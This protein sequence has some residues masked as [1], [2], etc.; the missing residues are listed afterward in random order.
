MCERP[1]ILVFLGAPPSSGTAPVD[2]QRRPPP[3]WRHLELT[4]QEGRLRPAAGE[5][6]R[7]PYVGVGNKDEVFAPSLDEDGR[8]ARIGSGPLSQGDETKTDRRDVLSGAQRP[9][10]N[11]DPN[12]CPAL[13]HECPG[14]VHE[15]LDF[16]FPAAQPELERPSES[17]PAPAAPLLSTQTQFL[18]SWTLSQALILRGVQSARSPAPDTPPKVSSSTPELFSPVAPS[19]PAS[20][21]TPRVKEGGVVI[22]A[23]ADGVL[24]SQEEQRE[25]SVTRARISENPRT[26][27]S[28]AAP[29]CAG[30][31]PPATLLIHCDR[32]GVRYSVLVAAVHPCH[33]REV[34]VRTGPSAG[35]F[36]PLASIV[37]TDQSGVEM[38]VVLWR[39]AAFWVSTVRPGDV[40]LITGLQ[41]NEDRWRGE[42]VLQSTF[43]SKLLNLGQILARTSPPV[44]RNIDARSLSALCVSLRERRPSLASLNLHAPQDP[45]RLPYAILRSLRVDTLA[46]ALLRVTHTH[47]STEWRS[48]AESRCT[49]AVQLKAT[50]TVEQPNNQQGVLLLWGSAVDWLPRFSRDKGAVWDFH[51]LLVRD[52]LTS[53]LPELHSTP[54]SAVQ[55]LD[56]ASRRAQEFSRL[57]P[58][59]TG[60][61]RLELDLDTL[62]SQ[63][64]GGDSDL[65]VQVNTFHFQDSPPSQ[66]ALQP[67]LDSSTS[68]DDITA[69]LCGDVTYTG[70][71]RCAAELDTD[72]NGIYCPCY[73][74]LPHT[75]ARRYYRPGVLTVS[76]R[77]YNQVCVQ[78]PPVL[79]HRILSAPPDKLHRSSA[80][81]SEVKH[82]QVAA[83]RI[84][85]LL[86]LPRKTFSITLR[87]HFLCDENSVPVHQDFTLLDLQFPEDGHTDQI[88]AN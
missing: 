62:L 45:N 34:K 55:P 85:A 54:W 32:H 29:D 1:K 41:V 84:Q 10:P 39:R 61:S 17:R 48:E 49:S 73:P 25:A 36:V 80:P 40:L 30:R 76:G 58:S 78:V 47:V 59:W 68:L 9:D 53:D 70:C 87:S 22:E 38:K 13:D 69:A 65:R 4:W 51:V 42:T 77:S 63:R 56:P 79:L 71:G 15:Y 35:T 6:F 3:P 14:S 31:R 64:H 75:A 12:P 2:E 57:R 5:A 50:L 16:S 24:C 26:D 8:E 81:G 7:D 44:P 74:C 66:N 20:C 18:A 33:L 21:L 23:N 37:V 52:G 82:V 67:V 19:P 46:H 86:S 28:A 88:Q 43:S 11:P 83:G 60:S 72:A 27:G